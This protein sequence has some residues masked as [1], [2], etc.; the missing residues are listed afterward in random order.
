MSSDAGIVFDLTRLTFDPYGRIV[1]SDRDAA[2]R[3]L[4]LLA[5]ADA[6]ACQSGCG[7]PLSCDT[8]L[9]SR[10]E[11]IRIGPDLIVNNPDFGTI[12]RKRKAVGAHEAVI[13]FSVYRKFDLNGVG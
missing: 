9:I 5:D 1:V 13:V 4:E 2:R 7:L 12:V 6:M 10:D 11:L 3:M 8:A